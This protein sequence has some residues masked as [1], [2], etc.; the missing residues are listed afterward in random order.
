MVNGLYTASRAMSN[1]LSK[2]DVHSQNL[3]NASTNGFKMAKLVNTAQVTVGRN[4]YGEL[5][6]KEMQQLSEVYTSFSQGPMVRTG[7]NFDLGLSSAGFFSVE[8]EDGTR[9]TRNGGFSMNSLG[10]LVTLSGKRVLDDAGAPINL[11]G[12]SVQFM[13]NGGVYVDGKKTATLGIFDFNDTKKLQYGQ[14]GLFGNTDPVN[15][16]PRA[17]ET[18]GVKSGFLEGS[19]ADPITTMVNMI[20]DFRNYEADQKTLQAI[21]QTLRQ[22]VTDVGRV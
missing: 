18:I 6:Q 20:A 19:N 15:N 14:D 16:A 13:E 17:P 21:D 4:D 9:F 5:K 22:A 12:D 7:N 11:K 3:A 10:E 1:I 8:A 2:Q